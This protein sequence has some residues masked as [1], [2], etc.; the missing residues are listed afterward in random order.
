MSDEKYTDELKS[1]SLSRDIEQEGVEQEEIEFITSTASLRYYDS[2]KPYRY[3]IKA[4]VLK[5]WQ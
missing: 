1:T 3:Y 4:Q 5:K 2:M